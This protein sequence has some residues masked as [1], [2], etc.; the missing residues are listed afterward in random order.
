MHCNFP[1][2]TN[3][4]V[5]KSQAAML[6]PVVSLSP[7]ETFPTFS[8][9]SDSCLPGLIYLSLMMAISVSVSEIRYTYRVSI[10]SD[11]YE[12]NLDIAC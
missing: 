5:L 7:S 12:L 6:S 4:L 1:I 3:E 11:L 9:L 8:L 2:H 10:V